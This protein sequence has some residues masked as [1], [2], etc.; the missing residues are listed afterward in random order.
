[1]LFLSASPFLTVYYLTL[2]TLLPV[3]VLVPRVLKTI[4]ISQTNNL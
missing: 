3:D 2:F 4:L 1:M